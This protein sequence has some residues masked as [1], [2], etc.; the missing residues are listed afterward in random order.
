MNIQIISDIHGNAE[1]L[2]Q[3]LNCPIPIDILILVGDYTNPGP[4]SPILDE[5]NPLLVVELL[6]A[7]EIPII[8]VRGNCDSEVDQSLFS[9]PMM[10]DDSYFRLG[11]NLIYITHG[12]LYNPDTD[13]LNKKADLYISGHTHISCI[14]RMD[15]HRI[16]FNPGS[17]ALPKGGQGSTY[18]IIQ[19][20]LLELRECKTHKILNTV[21]L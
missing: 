14:K 3:A 11:E 16:V 6:N 8:A 5:Y 18:G 4:K 19:Y 20:N 7:L 1:S 21:S 10:N 13:Y 2:R 15:G 12:H 9:F 17:V